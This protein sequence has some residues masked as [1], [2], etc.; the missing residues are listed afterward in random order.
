MRVLQIA[1]YSQE[2][3]PILIG[4]QEL[5]VHKLVLISREDEVQSAVEFGLGVGNALDIEVDHETVAREV[6]QY[7]IDTITTLVTKDE[8]QY[9]IFVNVSSSEQMMTC[10]AI[11]A[12]FVTGA[13]AFYIVK[14]AP[15]LLPVIKLS[16]ENILSESK[17][18]ILRTLVRENGE[19]VSFS[20]LS[21]KCSLDKSLVS[22]HLR[23][24]RD[25]R[26]LEELGL[27]SIER[28]K[29][30][31]VSISPTMLGKL[32]TNVNANV[33]ANV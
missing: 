7:M 25:T 28:G 29:Q 24:G 18:S 32:V 23:G 2:T 12:A 15:V 9:E 11:S 21:E 6:F 1:L 19:P 10:A 3:M 5:P 17:M 27:V 30:G 22:Y 16:Y 20:D 14:D 33:N 4:I 13:K 8:K 26:G 31:R